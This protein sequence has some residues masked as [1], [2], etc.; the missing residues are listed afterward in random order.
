MKSKNFLRGFHRAAAAAAV[1][2]DANGI[3]HVA[4]SEMNWIGRLSQIVK[5]ILTGWG[6]WRS[7]WLLLTHSHTVT[8]GGRCTGHG[9][10]VLLFIHRNKPTC[11]LTL[12]SH[13]PVF[14]LSFY[15]FFP[16]STRITVDYYK[17]LFRKGRNT[18]IILNAQCRVTLQEVVVRIS[19][20][21]MRSHIRGQCLATRRAAETR[22]CRNEWEERKGMWE[23]EMEGGK[24]E[25]KR[26]RER[27]GVLI[28][29]MTRERGRLWGA[30]SRSDLNKEISGLWIM[31]KL[32]A[33][34]LGVGC[35]ENWGGWRESVSCQLNFQL[36]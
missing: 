9:L 29:H 6:C 27:D 23:S 20:T 28:S 7:S 31:N 36:S 4:A 35:H 33:Q 14:G 5:L 32:E 30:Q 1:K 17:D 19:I 8:N 12:Y 24:R 13:S 34:R 2:S 26:K 21:H 10:F 3:F 22:S 25:R 16:P 15:A 18:S 11:L